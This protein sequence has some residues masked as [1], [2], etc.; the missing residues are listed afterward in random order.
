[1]SHFRGGFK[2]VSHMQ[3]CSVA[4]GK[5]YADI[6]VKGTKRAPVKKLG[7]P[8]GLTFYISVAEIMVICISW[9]W[10]ACWK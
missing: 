3:E 9:E 7:N 6:Q 5:L 2:C 4:F 10:K 8:I 1:M